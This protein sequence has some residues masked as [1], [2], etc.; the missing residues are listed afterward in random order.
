MFFIKLCAGQSS[1]RIR[2]ISEIG[3]LRLYNSLSLG[4]MGVLFIV[5]ACIPNSEK[6][7][8]L[9]TMIAA[10]CILGAN[11]GGFFKSSQMVSFQNTVIFSFTFT[12]ILIIIRYRNI[13]VTSHWLIFRLS[14]V[15]VCYSC[16]CS[17]TSSVSKTHRNNG[18][19]FSSF[20]AQFSSLQ[21]YSFVFSVRLNR[22]Y[23]LMN[24]GKMTVVI[25][26][27]SKFVQIRHHLTI[28]WFISFAN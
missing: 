27:Q 26:K 21:T 9:I 4:G 28:T 1:D 13:T 7:L 16:H 6:T 25:L 2:F 17:S 22:L 15:C 8:S 3:K 14:T 19:Q 12:F 20:T 18:L 10:T 23:G 24:C 5:L 11:S